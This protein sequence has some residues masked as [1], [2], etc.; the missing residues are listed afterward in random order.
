MSSDDKLWFSADELARLSPHLVIKIPTS[1]RQCR[2]RAQREKWQSRKVPGRGGPQGEKTEYL[3]PEDIFAEIKKFLSENP[4]FFQKEKGLT[5]KTIFYETHQGEPH[6]KSHPTLN[7]FVLVPRY[8]VRGSAGHGSIIHSEQIVDCLAF[9][10]DWVRH[11]LGVTEKD[12]VLISVKGDSMEP[13][14]NNGD[15]ILV[16][17]REDRIEDDAIYVLQ[18]DGALIVKRIQRKMDDSVIIKSDNPLYAQEELDSSKAESLRVLGR[19]VW[20]MR[21]I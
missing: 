20:F 6:A 10:A 21:K 12:L 15:L 5:E 1:S 14:I 19:V 8:D 2:A 9:R 16:S 4:D 17:T 3:P 11:T 7:D 13:T 18:R